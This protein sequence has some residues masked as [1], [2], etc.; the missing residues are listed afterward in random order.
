MRRVE[1]NESDF[2]GQNIY[3]RAELH[4]KEQSVMQMK[5]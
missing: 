1:I 3:A 4:F 2:K 5:L